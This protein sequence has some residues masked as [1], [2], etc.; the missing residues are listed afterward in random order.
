M[1]QHGF[2]DL[3]RLGKIRSD[4]SSLFQ[5][6]SGKKHHLSVTLGTVGMI[7]DAPPS[8]PCRQALLTSPHLFFPAQLTPL[9]NGSSLDLDNV[10]CK[11]YR[12]CAADRAADSESV[13]S[14]FSISADAMFVQSAR[15]EDLYLVESSR[16]K[17]PS[18]FPD[19]LREVPST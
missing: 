1:T 7:I 18:H 8:N 11:V 6:L 12:W 3:N 9:C 17:L 19:D 14:S 16:V 13:C 5:E 15:Y 10:Q 4:Q 2:S